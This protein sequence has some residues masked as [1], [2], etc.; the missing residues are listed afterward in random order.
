[1][2]NVTPPDGVE[3]DDMWLR[4]LRTVAYLLISAAGVLLILSPVLTDIYLWVAEIMAW[5]LAVGGA[6][7]F[8]GSLLKRWWGEFCGLPLLGSSFAVFAFIS[9][10]GTWEFAPYI[11]AANF[12]LLF[13]ISLAIMSRWRETWLSYR[14]AL[15]LVQ[16]PSLEVDDE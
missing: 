13:S 1:M 2:F 8:T 14:L 5:F 9:T 7:S 15:R 3:V 10:K 11:A 16:H 4:W 6:L 12:A